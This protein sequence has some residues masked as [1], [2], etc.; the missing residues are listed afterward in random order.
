MGERTWYQKIWDEIRILSTNNT[1]DI[2]MYSDTM[3]KHTP[4]KALKA[5]EET[6]LYSKIP[7]VFGDEDKRPSNDNDINKKWFT[8]NWYNS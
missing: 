2:H 6:L 5:F 3:L 7:V 4:K 1:V 8:F